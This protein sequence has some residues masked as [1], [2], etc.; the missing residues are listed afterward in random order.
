MIYMSP[1]VVSAVD[2]V[3]KDQL[4]KTRAELAD[5]DLD[6]SRWKNIWQI[7]TDIAPTKTF[8]T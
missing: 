4:G 2:I 7:S 6:S 8:S 5:D 1:H 3:M